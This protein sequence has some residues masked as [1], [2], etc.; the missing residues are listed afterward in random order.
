MLKVLGGTRIKTYRRLRRFRSA[1]ECRPGM[2]G[3][4]ARIRTSRSDRADQRHSRWTVDRPGVSD[5][6]YPSHRRFLQVCARLG[7]HCTGWGDE[8]AMDFPEADRGC[9]GY[10]RLIEPLDTGLGGSLSPLPS[11]V[12]LTIR[13]KFGSPRLLEM[14][15]RAVSEPRCQ[16]FTWNNRCRVS[17]ETFWQATQGVSIFRP[18]RNG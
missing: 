1:A 14:A 4:G 3:G 6:T 13:K 17:R 16:C 10:A 2:T 11:R 9:L 5:R 8:L 15:T 18:P 7:C 12:L